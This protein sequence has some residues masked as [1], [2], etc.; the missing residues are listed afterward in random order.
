MDESVP[1]SFIKQESGNPAGDKV[2]D[3]PTAC[4]ASSFSSNGTK[5]LSGLA[6]VLRA[7]VPPPSKKPLLKP[8]DNCCHERRMSRSVRWFFSLLLCTCAFVSF[9][10]IVRHPFL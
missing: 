5:D 6:C 8:A 1:L 7:P 10:C 3:I 4:S 2:L 9:T